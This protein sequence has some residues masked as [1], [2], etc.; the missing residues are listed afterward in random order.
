[1]R[2]L[3]WL[4]PGIPASLFEV[5]AEVIGG[6]LAFDLERSGPDHSDD[7]F[8]DGRVDI[9]WI[10]S[11]SFALLGTGADPSVRMVGV[12]WVPDDPDAAGRSVYFSDLVVRPDSPAQCLDDLA[13]ASIGGNDA[14]SLSGHHALRF[15]LCRRGHDPDRFADVVLTGGH[16]RSLDLLVAGELD[17][18]VVDSVVRRARSRTDPVTDGLRVVERLGP[19]PTQPLV[20]A[21]AV[22]ESVVRSVRDALLAAR[23]DPVVRSQLEAAALTDLIAVPDDHCRPV[24]EAMGGV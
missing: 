7:P 9:G 17:A 19:W 3:T 15:E 21:T 18:A 16:H 11:T 5:L 24:V 1:M 12:G 14:V 4:A 2:V 20:A 6:D 8:R 23:N 22:P 10:C 13:G